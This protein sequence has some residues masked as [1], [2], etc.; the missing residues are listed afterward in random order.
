[1]RTAAADDRGST[2]PLILG[3]F[4]IALLMVGGAVA[5]ADAYVQQRGLQDVCDGAA[6][7]A[8]AAAVQLDRSS[9]VGAGESLRFGDVQ[10]VVAEYLA[11]DPD[12]SGVRVTAALSDDEQTVVLTCTET[13]TI[14]FGAM[15]GEG[16]GV[17]HT[18][19]SAA[20]APLT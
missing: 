8:A 19:R 10:Q 13:S 15:F 11:R 3:F 12:R 1:M 5:A 16:D 9:D 14:A 20:R 7:S 6:E 4:L 18:V 17:T 2:I